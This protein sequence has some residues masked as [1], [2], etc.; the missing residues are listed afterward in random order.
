MIYAG[1][2]VGSVSCVYETGAFRACKVLLMERKASKVML[3]DKV[4]KV[5]KVYRAYKAYKV[6]LTE[7]KEPQETKV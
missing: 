4:I 6:L 3:A 1:W 5:N 2:I 7:R